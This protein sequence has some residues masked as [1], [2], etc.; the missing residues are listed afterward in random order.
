MLLCNQSKRDTDYKKYISKDI[1]LKEQISSIRLKI[2]DKEVSCLLYTSTSL[3]RMF[4]NYRDTS[5]SNYLTEIRVNKAKEL[6]DKA[7]QSY[8]KDIAEHCGYSDQFYFSRI[9]RSVT[10]MCPKEY[11]ERQ[12]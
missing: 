8:V 4:R 7:P 1:Y 9:F 6:M 10:G 12:C 3:S 11:M 2:Q 5:F